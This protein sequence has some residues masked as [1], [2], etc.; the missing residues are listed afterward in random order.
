MSLRIRSEVRPA[1]GSELG[2]PAGST[3]S[4]G[5]TWRTSILLSA[6]ESRPSPRP[7]V[8]SS[9]KMLWS[10]GRRRSAS[11]SRTRFLV[12]LAEGERQVGRRERLALAGHRARHHDH[13][14]ALRVVRVVQ[15]GR[16]PPVLLPR[17]RVHVLVDDDLLGQARVDPI[18]ER[19]L[20]RR[21]LCR[22]SEVS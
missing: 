5:D 11:I 17:R 6:V 3:A 22:G 16:E 21:R 2:R 9:R 15:H 7:S 10:V 19:A 20:G 4:R 13:L 12:R 14:Q 1:I 8:V 18:E